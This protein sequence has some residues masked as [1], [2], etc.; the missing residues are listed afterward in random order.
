APHACPLRRPPRARGYF[1]ARLESAGARRGNPS[2]QRR[3]IFSSTS[4]YDG[5]VLVPPT[6]ELLRLD[7]L[8]PMTFAFGSCCAPSI[9][10]L[11]W[12]L[13][14]R[15]PVASTSAPPSWIVVAGRPVW[16]VSRS[17]R[18]L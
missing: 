16:F 14:N 6:E 18:Y 13:H 17:D 5:A 3:H 11:L 10:S 4:S 9:D 1:P 2:V 7:S 12:I 8:T 15:R